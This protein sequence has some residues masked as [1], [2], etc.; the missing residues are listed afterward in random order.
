MGTLLIKI[1]GLPDT[2][3]PLVAASAVAKGGFMPR[4][5]TAANV[6]LARAMEGDEAAPETAEPAAE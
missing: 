2:E 1:A 5:K 3:V 4:M 6:L